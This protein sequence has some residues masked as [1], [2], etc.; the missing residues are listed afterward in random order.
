MLVLMYTNELT[1]PPDPSKASLAAQ[2]PKCV[3]RVNVN[4]TDATTGATAL[5]LCA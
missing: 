5:W 2:K 3:L 4:T 1:T